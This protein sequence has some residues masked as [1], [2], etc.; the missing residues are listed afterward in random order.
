MKSFLYHK[1]K[2]LAKAID[3]LTQHA[4]RIALLA[5]GTDLLVDIKKRLRA[6]SHMVD[7]KGLSSLE[8][9]D[10]NPNGSLRIGPLTT[11]SMIGRSPLLGKPWNILAQAASKVGSLQV[12]NRATIGGNICRASPSGDTLPALL[13]LEASVNLAGPSGPRT[14]LL[15]DFFHGPGRSSLQSNEILTDILLPPIPGGSVGIYKKLSLKKA[16]DL[17]VVGVAVLG[18]RGQA[19]GH[20]QEVRIA[21]GAVSPTPIRASGAE[22]RL[23]GSKITEAAIQEAGQVAV[24]EAQPISDLRGSEWYRRELIRHVTMQAIRE[25]VTRA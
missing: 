10:A 12:R 14:L 20:F 2:N 5:G 8:G 19:E 9:I 11:L 6:P 21:L 3:L 17:A 13:C 18:I 1:P 22:E 4:G 15:R 7:L 23:K 16:V 24:Q 25:L